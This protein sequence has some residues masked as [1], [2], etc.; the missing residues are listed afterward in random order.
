MAILK[1]AVKRLCTSCGKD[2]KSRYGANAYG[3]YLCDSCYIDRNP[4]I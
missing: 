1:K 3:A 2:Y 4:L